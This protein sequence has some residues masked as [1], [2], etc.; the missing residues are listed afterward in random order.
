[1]G[2][3]FRVALTFLLLLAP[4]P[5][6]AWGAEGHEV[7]AAIALR[8]LSPA[9]RARA[10]ALLGGDAMLIHDAN[11][12]DE[13]REQR[14]ET[15]RWHYVDIPLGAPGYDPRRDCAAGDCVVAQIENDRRMLG[16][17]HAAQ[18]ARIEALRFLVHFVGDI[19]QPL[20]AVDNDDKGGNAVRVYMPGERTNLHRVWD[21]AV[22][23]ALGTN[24]DALAGDI[25]G[26]IT[27]AQRKSW[28]AGTPADW[29]NES[30]GI[31][32]DEIYPMA[33]GRRTM[34]L[35]A[36]YPRAESAV[37]RQQLT[38][39]GVRLAWLINNTLR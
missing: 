10:A 12:A 33:R 7:I 9:A 6:F 37:V 27:P 30:Y 20:H 19:H 35:P 14:P 11:W 5:A 16:A 34:R 31:A 38:R 1:M 22:V 4:V 3:M 25:D 28:Q 39:A 15:G 8:E 17:P 29:A 32:R 2:A 26:A 24:A 23:E 36:S 13:I 18:Q 21:A